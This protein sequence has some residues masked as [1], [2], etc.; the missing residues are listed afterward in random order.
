MDSYHL[1][2]YD[3]KKLNIGMLCEYFGKCG[4]C[5]LY[6]LSYDEQK[7]FKLK[8]AKEL[9]APLWSGE[10]EWHS[11]QTGHYRTRAEF[12]IWHDGDDISYAMHK[13]K[14]IKES[15]PMLD[16][17]F[18]K[19]HVRN[20]LTQQGGIIGA[21]QNQIDK[22]GKL[23]IAN[24]PKVDKKIADLMPRLLAFIKNSE[25]LRQKLFGIEFLS[26]RDEVLATLLYHKKLDEAWQDEARGLC[27]LGIKVVGRSR[28][29]KINISEDFVRETLHI[30]DKEF[31]YIVYDTSFS[32]PNRGVNEQMI[33]WVLGKISSAKRADLLELYCGHGNFT[34]PLSFLFEKVLATEISKSSIHAAK[35]NCALNEAHNITF[36]R[37]SAQEFVSAYNREREFKRLADIELGSYNFSHLL[38][39]PPRAGLDEHSLRLASDFKNII[40]ISCNPKTL[41]DDLTKLTAT[42]KITSFALFDQFPYTHHIES[43]VIL[44]RIV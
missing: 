23:P 16:A 2:R 11:S 13:L 6:G 29:V 19:P 3:D 21:P 41:F 4:S 26:S 10:F 24:C 44:E 22:I 34:L 32:Q 8:D 39:D 9:F 33:S 42:H 43:G 12:M 25:I 40:Y 7:E 14:N 27:A 37:L 35:E 36:A 1:F 15:A 38:M 28:G 17:S 5:T 20:D 18:P 30:N 31:K